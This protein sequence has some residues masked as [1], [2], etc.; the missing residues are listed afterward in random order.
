MVHAV[1]DSSQPHPASAASAGRSVGRPATRVEVLRS[2]IRQDAE[3]LFGI[4]DH[5]PVRAM[6]TLGL[7]A[8]QG[9]DAVDDA[10]AAILDEDGRPVRVLP[11]PAL[12]LA[13]FAKVAPYVR[14]SLHPVRDAPEPDARSVGD[15]RQKAAELAERLGLSLPDPA[16]T[17]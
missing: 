4:A 15:A 17:A 1:L 12:A 8:W 11:D 9:Y 2:R 10:G 5:D 3:T 6:N 13:A 14:S 16:K 7:M